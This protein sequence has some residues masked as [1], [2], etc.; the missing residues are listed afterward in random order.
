MCQVL[1]VM[2]CSSG[3]SSLREWA[4]II[5]PKELGFLQNKNARCSIW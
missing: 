4:V 5:V 1:G 2:F 3:P